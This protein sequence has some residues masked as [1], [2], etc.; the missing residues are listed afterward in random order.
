MSHVTVTCGGGGRKSLATWKLVLD[1]ALINQSANY[2]H[3]IFGFGGKKTQIA[4]QPLK[5]KGGF[6]D[7]PN[8]ALI[9]GKHETVGVVWLKIMTCICQ[10]HTNS[11]KG[12]LQPD[13]LQECIWYL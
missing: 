3:H 10:Q 2:I 5:V 9:A 8:L 12:R 4:E 7:T 1:S 13:D 6:L 11:K